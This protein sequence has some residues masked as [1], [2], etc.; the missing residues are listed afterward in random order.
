MAA[1][2]QIQ[3]ENRNKTIVSALCKRLSLDPV[4]PFFPTKLFFFK[5]LYYL[6]GLFCYLWSNLAN[7]LN[8]NYNQNV[9]INFY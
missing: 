8:S 6:T 4:S 2:N 1:S 5:L 9:R 3:L 7:Q